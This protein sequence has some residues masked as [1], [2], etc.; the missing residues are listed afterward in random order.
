MVENTNVFGSCTAVA[1]L[2]DPGYFLFMGLGETGNLGA[3]CIASPLKFRDNGNDPH[4]VKG[5]Y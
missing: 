4:P 3:R 2:L 5:K 1:L